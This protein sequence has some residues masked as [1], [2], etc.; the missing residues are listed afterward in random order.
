M[1][2]TMSNNLVVGFHRDYGLLYDGDLIFRYK[3]VWN[4]LIPDPGT[5]LENFGVAPCHP[6]SEQTG[7]ICVFNIMVENLD[8]IPC[9]SVYS[10]RLAKTTQFIG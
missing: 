2:H 3:T 10:K 5:I 6:S 1:C 4:K 7:C 9:K 8:E